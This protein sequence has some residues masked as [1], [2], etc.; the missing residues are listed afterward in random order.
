MCMSGTQTPRAQTLRFQAAANRVT[1]TLLATPG[2]AQLLGRRLVTLYL[3]GRRSGRRLV[4][5]VAYTPHRGGLLIGTPFGWGRNLRT[6]EPVEVRYRGRRRWADV[7]VFT[8]EA[9]VVRLYAVMAKQNAAFASF[10]G[11]GHDASGEP[12]PR[13]LHLAWA[14]GARAFLLTVR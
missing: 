14:A 13:D 2:A 6:G 8:A 11:I 5:P 9:D 3:V 12:D 1:R 10:N 7:E 4:V